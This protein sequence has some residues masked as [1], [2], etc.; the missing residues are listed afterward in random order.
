MRI[1]HSNSLMLDVPLFKNN[2]ESSSPDTLTNTINFYENY[3]QL[4]RYICNL[5]FG[6]NLL[7]TLL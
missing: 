4:T 6:N 1:L 3:V 5:F 7:F 2:N